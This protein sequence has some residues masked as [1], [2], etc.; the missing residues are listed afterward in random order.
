MN[1]RNQGY[2]QAAKTSQI[3]DKQQLMGA[4]GGQPR[5]KTPVKGV[6]D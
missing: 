5:S 6:Q 1:M 2:Q 4:Q 3:M